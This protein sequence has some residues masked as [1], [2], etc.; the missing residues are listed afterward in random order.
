MYSL[1]IRAYGERECEVCQGKR[2]NSCI[3]PVVDLVVWDDQ[4]HTVVDI[5]AA[6][7]RRAGE[8]DINKRRVVLHP[9]KA[10]QKKTALAVAGEEITLA[11]FSGLFP[12][13]I[14]VGRDQAPA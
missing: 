10:G 3:E 4:G 2:I 9:K 1:S 6:R 11:C 7:L 13:E 14:A 5:V 12:F 8:Y